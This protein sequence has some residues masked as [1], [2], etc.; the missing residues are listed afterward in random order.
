VRLWLGRS[1]VAGE[2][3]VIGVPLLQVSV[4]SLDGSSVPT[5]PDDQLADSGRRH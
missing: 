2:M 4:L 5:L 1:V 3:H